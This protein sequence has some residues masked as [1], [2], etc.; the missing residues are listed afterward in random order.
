MESTVATILKMREVEVDQASW[1]DREG[2]NT[3]SQDNLE[4]RNGSKAPIHKY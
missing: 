2:K 3:K 1:Q 4:D